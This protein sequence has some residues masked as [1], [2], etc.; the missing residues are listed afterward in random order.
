MEWAAGQSVACFP[1]C[2][3]PFPEGKATAVGG[4]P[5]ITKAVL[6]RIQVPSPR[7]SQLGGCL[8]LPPH[9]LSQEFWK[10]SRHAE[11]ISK[12]CSSPLSSKALTKEFNALLVSCVRVC[13]ANH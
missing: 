2:V 13:G 10:A 6:T 7:C 1:D 5:G 9:I 3:S 8:L 4:E 12:G 11:L